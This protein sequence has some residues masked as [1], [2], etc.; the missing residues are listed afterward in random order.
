MCIYT[1]TY[2]YIPI[3]ICLHSF[4][5]L[6]VYVCAVRVTFTVCINGSYSCESHSEALDGS[7]LL[8]YIQLKSFINIII[9]FCVLELQVSVESAVIPFDAFRYM[10][11]CTY[12]CVFYLYVHMYV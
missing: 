11:A 3:Y 9:N 4:V 1:Q 10:C 5:S 2:M 12:I 7:L 8:Y 6:L